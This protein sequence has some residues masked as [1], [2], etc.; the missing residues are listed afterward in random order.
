MCS[1][2]VIVIGMASVC[3]VGIVGA[4]VVDSVSI[5]DIDLT[6]VVVGDD[7]GIVSVCVMVLFWCCV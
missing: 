2:I 7:I 3:V 6:N 5:I 4:G 1:G